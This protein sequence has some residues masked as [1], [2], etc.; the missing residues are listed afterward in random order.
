M[1]RHRLTQDAVSC[2]HGKYAPSS[3]VQGLEARF[4]SL[5]TVRSSVRVLL[6]PIP[7]LILKTFHGA[8][9][10]GTAL[11][12]LFVHLCVTDASE[13]PV[14]VHLVWHVAIV[15]QPLLLQPINTAD[16]VTLVDVNQGIRG[17][18]AY[19]RQRKPLSATEEAT[20]DFFFQVWPT[21]PKNRQRTRTCAE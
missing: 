19:V 8:A 16:G 20:D 6:S 5:S 15:R 12:F 17:I 18:R 13:T 14:Y 1:K 7:A 4:E 3:N 9:G 11:T 2:V 21:F 10:W